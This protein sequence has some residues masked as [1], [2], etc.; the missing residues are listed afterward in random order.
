MGNPQEASAPPPANF[1]MESTQQ[2]NPPPPVYQP[3]QAA[4]PVLP[5][6]AYVA[7]GQTHPQGF[8]SNQPQG[9]PNQ[10]QPV[11]QTGAQ[12]NLI[13]G[14]QIVTTQPIIV[15]NRAIYGQTPLQQI[16][17]FCQANVVT[18]VGHEMGGGSWLICLGL[19]FFTGCCCCLPCCITGLQDA[20]HQ[21]PNCKKVVGRK[22]LM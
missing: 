9:F 20:V 19:F 10:A 16:C 1:G 13:P 6:Q 18:N 2:A 22:N 11:F 12:A 5:Q 7:N 15:Q 8:P 3:A 14:A 21:C 17:Q 4:Y